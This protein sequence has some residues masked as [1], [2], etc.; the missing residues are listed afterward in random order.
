MARQPRTVH[1]PDGD[2]S[3][4][5]YG[6][7]RR[8]LRGHGQRLRSGEDLA[9]LASIRSLVPRD[10]L[11]YRHAHLPQACASAIASAST[12]APVCLEA[13]GF[14]VDG[15]TLYR[16][17]GL[18]AAES[19]TL[20][21]ALAGLLAGGQAWYGRAWVAVRGSGGSHSGVGVFADACFGQ[22]AGALVLA[23]VLVSAAAVACMLALTW[24]L[25]LRAITPLLRALGGVMSCAAFLTDQ[26]LVLTHETDAVDLEPSVERVV[27]A[28]RL[29][30]RASFRG[31]NV[32][33]KAR[34]RECACD[35][36]LAASLP[37]LWRPSES[38]IQKGSKSG[39]MRALLQLLAEAVN[40]TEH[41]SG[42]LQIYGLDLRA[43]VKQRRQS[44]WVA[45]PTGLLPGR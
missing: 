15:A 33:K 28:M 29:L 12:S 11:S 16:A 27:R 9:P 25:Y 5:P 22:E 3:R 17:P 42:V 39:F 1:G 19:A 43:W 2:G 7:P 14:A 10:A 31:R 32:V 40:A 34:Q 6:R 35:A 23:K 13:L 20:S 41:D 18:S 44:G 8:H 37:L 38:G 26:G 21:D 45:K 36:P 30:I 4:C 24:S